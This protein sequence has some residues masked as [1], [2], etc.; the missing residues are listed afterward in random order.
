MERAARRV[1]RCLASALRRAEASRPAPAADRP[2]ARRPARSAATPRGPDRRHARRRPLL[3]P[4]GRPGLGLLRGRVRDPTGRAAGRVGRG[5]PRLLRLELRPARARLQAAA[6]LRPRVAAHGGRRPAAGRQRGRRG[7]LLAQSAD[8]RPRRGGRRRELGAGDADRR[9]SGVAG[10]L[11]P[12]PGR[13]RGGGG[14]AG[15]QA[16]LDLARCRRRD[17]RARGLPPGRAHPDRRPV[18]RADRGAGPD[19][20]AAPGRPADRAVRRRARHASWSR[21]VSSPGEAGWIE[22]RTSSL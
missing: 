16:P 6:R 12:R 8:Q 2:A 20:E 4:R 3:V 15:R 17:R 21:A 14:D 10:P 9:R 11:H 22:R 19:R 7:R 5:R 13:P 18:A 1:A